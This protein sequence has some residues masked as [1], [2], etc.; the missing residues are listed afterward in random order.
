LPRNWPPANM[1]RHTGVGVVPPLLISVQMEV[2]DIQL[3]ANASGCITARVQ[4][5]MAEDSPTSGSYQKM[6]TTLEGL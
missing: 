3:R 6:S 2:A 4:G 1:K 5:E